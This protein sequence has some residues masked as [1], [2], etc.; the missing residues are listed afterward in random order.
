MLAVAELPIPRLPK[1]HVTV[2]VPEHEPC[3]GVAE[4]KL[5][6]AGSVSVMVV[7]VDG[8][9]PLFV[10]TILYVR[11]VATI[12]GFGDA[13]FVIARLALVAPATISDAGVLC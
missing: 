6:P 3:V 4:T 7:F 2:V 11:L 1:L 5:T 9:G 8:E 13:V 10:T 12:A